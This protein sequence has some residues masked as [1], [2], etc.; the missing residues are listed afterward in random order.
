MK[1]L[2]YLLYAFCFALAFLGLISLTVQSNTISHAGPGKHFFTAI[3]PQGWGFFTR[4]PKDDNVNIYLVK[5]NSIKLL[6]YPNGSYKNYFGGS[7]KSRTVGMEISIIL[8]KLK[9]VP[10]DTITVN[11]QVL[12]MTKVVHHINSQSL[13]YLSKGEYLL[14]K[15][16]I[17]PWAWYGNKYNFIPYETIHVQVD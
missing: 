6:S 14:V 8:S 10:W 15:K 3:A 2:F 1:N 12:H 17:T 7:R 4:T 11:S 5:N 9:T 16:P 13:F